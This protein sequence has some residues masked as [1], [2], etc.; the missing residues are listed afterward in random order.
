VKICILAAGAGGMYCGSCMRDNA[1]ASALLRLGH[2]V[3]LI[4]L[5]TPMKT[6]TPSASTG[7]VFFGGINIYLQ[8]ASR[9]FRKTPRFLDWLFDR[10]WM[11]NLAANYGTRAPVSELGGLTLDLLLGEQ[12][13]AVKEVRRLA[14]FIRDEIRPDI[15]TLP[16]LMFMGAA[17]LFRQELKIPVI[18]ELTG[19]DIFLDALATADR[20]RARQIIRE[21]LPAISQFVATSH[22]YADQMAAYLGVDRANIHVVY[23]GLA[24]EFM[25]AVTAHVPVK[26]NRPPTVGYLARICPEKGLERLVDAMILL[27]GLPGMANVQLRCAGYLGKRDEPFFNRLQQRIEQ[28]PLRGGFTYVGEVDQAGKIDLLS[29]IDVFSAPSVYAESKGIYVLE[30]MAMGVPV[31]QPAHGSFP[32]LLAA[33]GGGGLTAPGDAPALAAAL[34]AV[35]RD[36]PGRLAQGQSARDIVHR[37]FTD[38]QMATQMLTIYHKALA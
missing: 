5:Y 38:T 25:D 12:G 37:D 17:R 18:C 28:S 36:E 15:V 10:N 33:T 20:E 29:S 21:R 13:T 4:P 2:Q 3:T 24:K 19:E 9:L 30:A 35:L 26:S 6:D 34:A 31:V 1:L 16:N 27:R 22:Y 11:L 14:D 32:E 7:R 8:H 23:P